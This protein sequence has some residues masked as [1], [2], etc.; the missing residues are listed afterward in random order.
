MK[1]TRQTR[2]GTAHPRGILRELKIGPKMKVLDIGCGPGFHSAIARIKGAEVIPLDIE[3]KHV[4]L[5]NKIIEYFS[6]KRPRRLKKSRIP[7]ILTEFQGMKIDRRISSR[8]KTGIVADARAL[9]FKDEV[10]DRMIMLEVLQHLG[11]PENKYKA[12]KEAYRV[13]KP[14]GLALIHTEEYKNK[15]LEKLL[16]KVG[17][18]KVGKYVYKKG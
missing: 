9:P 16:K 18:E 6:K 17:F 11:S 4:E 5:A 7:R 8:K 10:F 14:G 13:L 3:R 15:G 12:L 1:R 2:Y